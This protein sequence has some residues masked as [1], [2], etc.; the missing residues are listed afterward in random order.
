MGGP[1]DYAPFTPNE[2]VV[3]DA[4]GLASKAPALIGRAS[5]AGSELRIRLVAQE[6]CP[7]HLGLQVAVVRRPIPR[8]GSP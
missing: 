6:V 8:R 4:T 3:Y 2:G 7:R 1:N 5:I